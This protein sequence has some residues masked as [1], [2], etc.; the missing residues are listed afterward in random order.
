MEWG[1]LSI[2]SL[3]PGPTFHVGNPFPALY[4]RLKQSSPCSSEEA[5]SGKEALKGKS[6]F[7]WV[8]I[9]GL[10]GVKCKSLWLDGGGEQHLCATKCTSLSR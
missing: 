6:L 8:H 5:G 7:K 4:P 3:S 10:M 2:D 9:T 1:F